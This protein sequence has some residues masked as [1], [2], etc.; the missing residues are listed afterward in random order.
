[1]SPWIQTYSGDK[2]SLL[3]PRAEDI[4]LVDIAHALSLCNRFGG[5]TLA[6]Y[7][8]AQHSIYTVQMLEIMAPKNYL[9][10]LHGLLHDASEAYLGDIVRPLKHTMK[11]YLELEQKTQWVILRALGVPDIST[12][13]ELE[14]KIAD[15]RVLLAERSAF[16]SVSAHAWDIRGIP[17]PLD[18]KAMKWKKTEQKFLSKFNRL[19]A[20]V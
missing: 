5:H 8:V 3:D 11:E 19:K 14:V 18:I 12:K 17:A 20:L 6:P 1:M 7:S 16:L 15:N 10:H 13:D 2:H 4:H 9:L